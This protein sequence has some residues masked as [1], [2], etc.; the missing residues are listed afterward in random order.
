[1]LASEKSLR[2]GAVNKRTEQ[3]ARQGCFDLS[4][5]DQRKYLNAENQR[6]MAS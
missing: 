1:M 6:S 3:Q 2:L 5:L 4:P